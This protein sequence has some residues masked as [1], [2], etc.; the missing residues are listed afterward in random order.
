MAYQETTLLRDAAATRIPLGDPVVLRQGASYQ[1]TQALGGTVTL[2][3]G[4]GLYRLGPEEFEALEPELRAQLKQPVAADAT[5]EFGEEQVWNALRQCYD[6]E[7]PL[8]IVDLGLIYDL[9]LEPQ[10]D[11]QY[12]V[13]V[14]MTLTAPG[15]GM[16]PAIAG[17]AQQKIEALPKVARAQV[18]IVWDPQWTPQMIS[19]EGRQ[20]LGLD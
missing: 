1:I 4:S 19:A 6:P 20:V 14:K 2:R 5:G 11:G 3:D 13:F 17:D 9:R 18:D 15:C 7:I 10:V 8:N 12:G 16:G